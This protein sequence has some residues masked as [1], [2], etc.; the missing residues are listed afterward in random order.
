MA[1]EHIDVVQLQP[2][3]A[4]LHGVED[5]LATEPV[6]VDVADRVWVDIRREAL[7]DALLDFEVDLEVG[8]G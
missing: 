7:A 3:Q 8:F 5:V 4:V 6:L 1:L 2:L